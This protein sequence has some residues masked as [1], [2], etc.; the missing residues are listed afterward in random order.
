MSIL[1]I[2]IFVFYRRIF[3]FLREYFIKIVLDGVYP[4]VGL[5]DKIKGVCYAIHISKIL[6][7]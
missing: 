6:V 1:T 2:T 3:Y 5:S 7:R 4:H